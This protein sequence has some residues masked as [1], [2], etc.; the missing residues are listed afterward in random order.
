M[1]PRSA[2]RLTQRG[3]AMCLAKVAHGTRGPHTSS[4][5]GPTR[6]CSPTSAASTSI[7]VVVRFSPNIPS[8]RS[9]P[10]SAPHQSISSRATA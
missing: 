5:V 9:R 8:A 4:R 7:P 6:H 2:N 10:S 1:R 3:S